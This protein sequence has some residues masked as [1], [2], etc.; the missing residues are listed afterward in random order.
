MTS[1]MNY[2]YNPRMQEGE[3]EEQVEQEEEKKEKES[4]YGAC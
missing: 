1:P 3:E 4:A 2:Q